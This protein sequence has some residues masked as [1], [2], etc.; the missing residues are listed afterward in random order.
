[1]QSGLNDCE[2]E[3]RTGVPRRTVLEWRHGRIPRGP[4][5][6]NESCPRC[7]HAPHDF[8]SL[9][10]AHYVYLLGIFLGD[11]FIA[12]HARCYRL[13]VFLDRR[14]Q[15]IV[16]E[17]AEAIAA[18]MPS[19]KVGVY[20]RR[21]DGA[22]EVSSYSRA[23]PCV[24]PQHGPGKKHTR[25][26]DLTDWQRGL[27]LRR[28]DR[29]LRGLIHSDG[30]RHI[31]TIRH[32]QKTYRYPRYEF[33]NR[34]DD[35]RALFCDTCDLLGIEWRVMNAKTISVARRDSVRALDGFVGPKR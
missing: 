6:A 4:R 27:V 13:V 28:P 7:G 35:I 18:V 15:G 29:L 8:A 12:K 30:C 16:R 34:S 5:R 25:Q 9:P 21:R 1:M 2:I 32:P 26:I 14:Y 3:R 19:S 22:D 24:I 23:W 31:N 10:L 33:T 20:Q 17:C 11:G